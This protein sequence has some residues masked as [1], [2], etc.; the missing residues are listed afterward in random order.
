MGANILEMSTDPHTIKRKFEE[1]IP[2]CIEAAVKEAVN[3]EKRRLLAK[4]RMLERKRTRE[5]AVMAVYSAMQAAQQE[6]E[7]EE[8]EQMH[9]VME[10]RKVWMALVEEVARRADRDQLQLLGGHDEEK[11]EAEMEIVVKEETRQEVV[12]EEEKEEE[13]QAA[14]E[15]RG[16]E[17][18]RIEENH[19]Q[20]AGLQECAAE[21]VPCAV[22]VKEERVDA[23]HSTLLQPLPIMVEA[24]PLMMEDVPMIADEPAMV[25]A[26]K[27]QEEERP[28]MLAA[29][30]PV[31]VPVTESPTV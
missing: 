11:K 23:G 26:V 5:N 20:E 14:G 8:R 28:V 17:S 13:K 30:A 15:E 6:R 12:V 24:A 22:E 19:A 10:V 1:F 31:A 18:T 7:R 25:E 27:E 21:I 29:S 16:H 2:V 4:E 9:R 3:L